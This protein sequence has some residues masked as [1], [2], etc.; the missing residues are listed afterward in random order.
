MSTYNIEYIQMHWNQIPLSTHLFNISAEDEYQVM[1]GIGIG[2]CDE[3][4][5]KLVICIHSP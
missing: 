2:T 5:L 1:K 3:Q 4:D